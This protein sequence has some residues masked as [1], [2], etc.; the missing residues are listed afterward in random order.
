MS[1]K[2]REDDIAVCSSLEKFQCKT[3]FIINNIL[4]I[5]LGDQS[6]LGFWLEIAAPCAYPLQHPH[7]HTSYDLIHLYLLAM[8]IKYLNIIWCPALL[9]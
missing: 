8:A 6:F 5:A 3:T 2:G 9:F 7:D 4:E 1:P